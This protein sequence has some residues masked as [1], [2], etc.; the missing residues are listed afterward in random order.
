M[1]G[2]RVGTMAV[3]QLQAFCS[4]HHAG[5]ASSRGRVVSRRIT[6]RPILA[7]GALWCEHDAMQV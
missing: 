1:G 5:T 6:N 3:V 4:K 7:G 2:G